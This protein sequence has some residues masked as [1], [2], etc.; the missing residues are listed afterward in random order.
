[1]PHLE[2]VLHFPNVQIISQLCSGCSKLKQFSSVGTTASLYEVSIGKTV[3]SIGSSA[4]SQSLFT[5][6]TFEEG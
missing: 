5:K 1:M 3:T 2:N 4:F 6:I